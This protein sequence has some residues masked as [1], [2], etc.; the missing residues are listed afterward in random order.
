MNVSLKEETII[1]ELTD[2]VKKLNERLTD[3][4]VLIEAIVIRMNGTCFRTT[5]DKFN[6]KENKNNKTA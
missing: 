1:K 3:T 5:F 4:L 6:E 2:S